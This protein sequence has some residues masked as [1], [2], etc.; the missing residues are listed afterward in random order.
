MIVDAP[1]AHISSE[2]KA[3]QSKT[4]NISP[5]SSQHG[6]SDERPSIF[7]CVFLTGHDT[8]VTEIQQPKAVGLSEWL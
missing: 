3:C 5:N 1:R 4:V 6:S 7:R 8:V 2:Q